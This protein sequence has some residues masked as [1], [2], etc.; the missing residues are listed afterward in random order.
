M[1]DDHTLLGRFAKSKDER[2]F[3]ELVRR[4]LDMVYRVCLR[5]TGS[6]P[7]AEEL[8][9]NVFATLARKASWLKPEVLVVG[10]LHRA[11]HLESRSASR[12]EASRLR[13]MKNYMDFQ[14]QTEPEP[15]R[16]C[17]ISPFLDQALDALPPADR[18]VILLRFASDLTLQQIGSQLGK[19]E[20]AAQR[21]LQRVLE[22]LA[23][24]LRR[25]GVTTSA[26]ALALL[27]GADF[28]KAA[29]A[30][31]TFA[32][33]SKTAIASA[34]ATSGISI[35]KIT[36]L[37]YLMKNK[38][39]I[40]ASVCLLTAG[41]ATLYLTAKPSSS[42]ATGS[43]SPSSAAIVAK[44]S[45]IG[46]VTSISKNP[47]T[48]MSGDSAKNTSNPRPRPVSDYRELEEKYGASRVR[49]TKSATDS[50]MKISDAMVQ[51]LEYGLS[52]EGKEAEGGGLKI[53]MNGND[54]PLADVTG[55]IL[56]DEQKAQV[57]AMQAK[58]MAT[59]L[60]AVR[61][62]QTCFSKNRTEVMEMMLCSD[63]ANRGEMSKGDYQAML[64][65]KKEE[66]VWIDEF[67]SEKDT[68]Q[69]KIYRTELPSI[70][71]KDQMALFEKFRSEQEVEEA[72]QPVNHKI[73]GPLGIMR[74]SEGP[75]SD[76]Q[77]LEQSDENLRKAASA[78]SGMLK[79]IESTR[80]N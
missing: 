1:D 52:Q 50:F 42:V 24:I 60:D 75:K 72:K 25:R 17:E 18:D 56:S 16:F 80:G 19:S 78:F 68:I 21:H 73:V 40:I 66:I 26:T 33:V 20:S 41:G 30:S 34:A 6:P 64:D 63:A 29:P 47:V 13:K 67:L 38:A 58:Q 3:T 76:A 70:L 54:D 32:F 37:L 9:Q 2:A 4:H 10:W 57:K 15:D 59:R 48:A 12:S 8:V 5:R 44:K 79:M 39:I 55:L 49:L 7:L 27:L 65:G 14:P 28:A 53:T 77:T 23:V 46:S 31:L 43:S 35:L 71:D 69:N 62:M 45:A 74:S 11:A 51:I 36:T 61:T 22:K